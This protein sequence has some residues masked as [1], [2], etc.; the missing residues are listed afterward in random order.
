MINL[1]DPQV[2]KQY[3]PQD[4]LTHI[5]NGVM[6]SGM[7]DGNSLCTPSGLFPDQ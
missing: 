1:D 5:H 7:A 4:M 6:P 3:D 2:Y